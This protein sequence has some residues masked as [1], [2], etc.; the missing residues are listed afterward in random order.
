MQIQDLLFLVVAV[1]VVDFDP[2]HLSVSSV[3]ES[4][5]SVEKRLLRIL[6]LVDSGNGRLHPRHEVRG[7]N[8][9]KMGRKIRT[10]E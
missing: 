5:S 10:Y 3:D 7:L 2:V 1:A 8:L 4:L 9:K 6:G